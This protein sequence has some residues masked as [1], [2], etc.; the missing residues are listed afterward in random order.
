[1][2]K[3]AW[4]ARPATRRRMKCRRRTPARHATRR[5]RSLKP[6][7]TSNQKIRTRRRITARI[8]TA[9][10]ATSDTKRA[11]T[12][13]TS[14]T[15]SASRCLDRSALYWLLSAASLRPKAVPQPRTRSRKLFWRVQGNLP[16]FLPAP[17]SRAKA[18]GSFF[19]FCVPI[20]SACRN[21]SRVPRPGMSRRRRP[22]LPKPL[23]KRVPGLER[24]SRDRALQSEICIDWLRV[25]RRSV[26]F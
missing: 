17:P 20:V 5:T 12:S 26:L 16:I 10:T 2:R 19:L 8:S 18:A 15:P 25:S 22:S 23:A 7:R 3:K 6:Q 1:M 4:T 11:S 9:T 24:R 21:L 13:A 14:A